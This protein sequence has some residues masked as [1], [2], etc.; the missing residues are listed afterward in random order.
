M[1]TAI[2]AAHSC[3]GRHLHCTLPP[4]RIPQLQRGRT[5]AALNACALLPSHARAT[6]RTAMLRRQN[7]HAFSTRASPAHC[8]TTRK[9]NLSRTATDTRASHARTP[10]HTHHTLH[11]HTHHTPHTCTHTAHTLHTHRHTLPHRRYSCFKKHLCLHFSTKGVQERL[12]RVALRRSPACLLPRTSQRLPPL[13]RHY[14]YHHTCHTYTPHRLTSLADISRYLGTVSRTAAGHHHSSLIIIS[15]AC[16][17]LHAGNTM[18]TRYRAARKRLLT[19]PLHHYR[20][21][22]TP[23]PLHHCLL[24]LRNSTHLHYMLRAQPSHTGYSC[25]ASTYYLATTPGTVLCRIFCIAYSP[26]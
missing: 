8:A 12:P 17:P 20:T 7:A 13:S 14:L 2:S 19:A 4:V 16:H 24:P 9:R 3:Y 11:T 25:A 5:S 21:P 10:A 18:A 26:P 23:S 1:A 6:P 15:T 22:H